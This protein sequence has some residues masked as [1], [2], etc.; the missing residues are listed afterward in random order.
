MSITVNLDW[1]AFA[2]IGGSVVLGIFVAKMDK[3]AVERVSTHA[4]D[5]CKEVAVA[6]NANKSGTPRLPGEAAG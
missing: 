1:K 4:V 6:Y 2:A 3:P 5:A